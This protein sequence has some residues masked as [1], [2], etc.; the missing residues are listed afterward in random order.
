[1]PSCQIGGARHQG[2]APPRR[3]SDVHQRQR[4]LH[5]LHRLRLAVPK[6]LPVVGI[7]AHQY[8][9]LPGLPGSKEGG[10]PG[11]TCGK[12]HGAKVEEPGTADQLQVHLILPQLTVRAPDKAEVPLSGLVHGYDGHGGGGLSGAQTGH[13]HSVLLEDPGEVS[14]EAVGPYLSHK[15]AEAPRRAA[16]TATLAGAPPGLAAK[17]GTRYSFTPV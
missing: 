16:D 15:G 6:G 5:P 9:H 7:V 4:L 11:G 17:V 3:S 12:A 14:A 10:I 1:M 13:I 8:A 2:A